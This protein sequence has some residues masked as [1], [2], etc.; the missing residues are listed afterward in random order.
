LQFV[1]VGNLP[2]HAAENTRCF[3]CGKLIIQRE[4]Y[5]T[6]I[7]GL[8]GTRCQYCGTDLNFRV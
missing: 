8:E 7:L 3:N 6:T 5:D 1:Y 4:G 2:G